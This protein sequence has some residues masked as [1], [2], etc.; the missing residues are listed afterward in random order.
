MSGGDFEEPF[1]APKIATRAAQKPCARTLTANGKRAG[2]R[3]RMPVFLT[4]SFLV[5][6]SSPSGRIFEAWLTSMLR[7][8]W[9]L[10]LVPRK[11][12]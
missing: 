1:S 3:P 4:P 12:P 7:E 5:P 11:M 9:R 8:E 2:V 6:C 10:M